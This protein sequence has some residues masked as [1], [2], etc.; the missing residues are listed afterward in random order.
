MK[1][2]I[3][4]KSLKGRLEIPPTEDAIKMRFLKSELHKDFSDKEYDVGDKPTECKWIIDF[5]SVEGMVHWCRDLG[6]D[7]EIRINHKLHY[8]VIVIDDVPKDIGG[9]GARPI[10]K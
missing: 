9:Y 4:R 6:C 2:I 1:F 7:I 5:S 8:P 3:E 10:F